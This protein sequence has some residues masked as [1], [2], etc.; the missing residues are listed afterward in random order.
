M[1]TFEK[2]CI[3]N[4]LGSYDFKLCVGLTNGTDAVISWD[5]MN[6]VCKP[7]LDKIRDCLYCR[8][9]DLFRRKG[10]NEEHALS[11]SLVVA[12]EGG[13]VMP[14]FSKCKFWM[15]K[16]PVPRSHDPDSIDR[17]YMWIQPRLNPSKI[18]TSLVTNGDSS[19]FSM[20]VVA[21]QPIRA[22][23]NEAKIHAYCDASKEGFGSY[24]REQREEF[25]PSH[26]NYL[27]G[28]SQTILNC[29]SDARNHTRDI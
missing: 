12:L 5:L 27:L 10:R 18:G 9:S 6:R 19:I 23:L 14:S 3:Q 22:L 15:P 11:K 21:V 20:K 29:Q 2:D 16:V 25:K 24:E 8:Y 4:S 28:S 1:K 26:G 17:K 13:V 7:Y